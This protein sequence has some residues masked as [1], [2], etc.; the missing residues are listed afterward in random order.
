LLFGKRS[1]I[2]GRPLYDSEDDY[3]DDDGDEDDNNCWLHDCINCEKFLEC[4]DA[5]YDEEPIVSDLSPTPLAQMLE[6]FERRLMVEPIAIREGKNVP[7]WMLLNPIKDRGFHFGK[8]NL[9]DEYYVGKPQHEDGNILIIG[10]PG[11]GKTSAMVKP[12]LDSWGG[13]IVI[14]D[15]K[16][17]GDLLERCYLSG[18]QVL[19]FNPH[20]EDACGFDP[21]AFLRA[22]G[23]DNLARNAKELALALIDTVLGSTDHGLNVSAQNL[24]A[25]I[26]TFHV[27]EGS[28]FKE[29]MEEM[30]LLSVKELVKTIKESENEIARM[31]TS[32]L[33]GLKSETLAG[34]GMDLTDLAILAADPLI[35]AALSSE[36][37]EKIIDWHK[38][39]AVT[40]QPSIIVLQLPEENLDTWEPMTKLL[41]NQ[42]I[43][44]L[45]RRPDKYSANGDASPPVLVMLE[46]FP[47]LGKISS[48][49]SGLATLRSRG[50]TFCLVIQEIAQLDELYGVAG[51]RKIIGTCSYKA[52]LKVDEPD[53]MEYCSKLTGSLIVPNR[54]VSISYKSTTGEAD[55]YGLQVNEIR[56]PV[57]FPHEFATLSDVVLITPEG[58]CR[59]EKVPYY[60]SS[61]KLIAVPSEQQ[62]TVPV[63]AQRIEPNEPLSTVPVMAQRIEPNCTG[64]E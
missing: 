25:G 6:S 9:S 60:Q 34:I 26:I 59:V 24:L 22:D 45:Q 10:G 4:D 54:S 14:I 42:L 44:T 64:G 18:K 36:G 31:F 50:V 30:Q 38:L 1:P 13:H 57:V 17:K 51:R 48:I 49:T 46:E 15:V 3:Y 29:A 11:C 58:Y 7:G 43:R 47:S 21:F 27:T 5:E 16:P 61:P 56:E 19:V 39:N 32:K 53:S 23:K 35:G 40:T 55:N 33:K 12:S 37:K 8:V 63:M 62:S 2:F 41:I 28:S 20:K 52:I